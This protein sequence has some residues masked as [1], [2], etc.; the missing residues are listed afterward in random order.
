MIQ[1]HDTTT[2][3]VLKFP[4]SESAIIRA[5]RIK[6]KE[7]DRSAWELE[8]LLFEHNDLDLSPLAKDIGFPF[9]VLKKMYRQAWDDHKPR[10]SRARR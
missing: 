5:A 3:Q 8:K 9:V 10:R 1:D 7:I 4:A 6:L 2:N